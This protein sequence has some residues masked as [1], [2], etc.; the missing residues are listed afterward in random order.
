M[1]PAEIPAFQRVDNPARISGAATL[2]WLAA[3][4]GSCSASLNSG[5]NKPL[6][7]ASCA[8]PEQRALCSRSRLGQASLPLGLSDLEIQWRSGDLGGCRSPSW[9]VS[10]KGAPILEQGCAA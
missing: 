8:G 5:G 6:R 9:R 10:W 4:Q 3:H 7:G 1:C 2:G